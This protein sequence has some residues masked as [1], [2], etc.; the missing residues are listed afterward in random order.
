MEE[1]LRTP[2][3]RTPLTSKFRKSERKNIG[4]KFLSVVKNFY[5]FKRGKKFLKRG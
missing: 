1:G 2:F 5:F 3:S 4:Q